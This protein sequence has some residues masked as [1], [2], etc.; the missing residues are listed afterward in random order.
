MKAHL[1]LLFVALSLCSYAQRSALRI[2]PAT[3]VKDV[4]VDDLDDEYQDIT[5]LTVTNDSPRSIQL[6]RKQVIIGKPSSWTF[7]T[8]S[9]RNRNAPYV[10]SEANTSNDQPVSLAPGESATFHVVLQPD[11]LAGDGKMEVHF[12]DLNVPGQLLG[13]A[14]ITTEL[15]QRAGPAA[16]PSA[17]AAGNGNEQAVPT[18][19]RLYPNPA[20]E[21]FFVET[22]PGVKLGRIEVSNTLGKSLLKFDRPAGKDGYEVQNLPDGLY[23]I[24]IFD[25]KGKKL[26]TLRLLHRQFGA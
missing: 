6:V 3:V 22:P 15:I 20:R 13:K 9:R 12:S 23:L 25:D 24:S 14:S 19:V 7:G 17:P 4:V 10:I 18:T 5:T 21:R 16:A 8:F 11:G 1:F 26:K 2:E